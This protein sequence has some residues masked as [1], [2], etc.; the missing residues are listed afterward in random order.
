MLFWNKGLAMT[1]AGADRAIGSCDRDL[2]QSSGRGMRSKST[3]DHAMVDGSRRRWMLL[4]AVLCGVGL[5]WC[6]W[7]WWTDRRTRSAM[8]EIESEIVSGRYAIACRNLEKLLSW[9]ADPNGGIAYLLGSCELARGRPEAAGLAWARVVPGSAFSE[10]AIRGRMRLSYQSGEQAGAERVIE[11]AALD[12]RSDRTA[13]RAS[14]VPMF[15]E[16]GRTD[17]AERLIEDRWEHL[18]AIGEGALEPAIKLLLLHIGLTLTPTPVEKVRAALEQAA[19]LAPDDDRVW[20]GRANLAIRTGDYDEASRCLDECERLR[21]NDTPVW[22]ARLNWGIATNRINVVQ[23]A[24]H[25]LPAAEATPA[26]IGRLKVWFAANRH[27][28]GG[29]RRELESLL[30]SDPADRTALDRL[31][32]LAEIAGD[33]AQAVELR[34]RK[35]E[36]DALRSRYEKLYERKQPLRHAVEMAHLAERL[37]RR[38]EAQVFLTLAIHADPDREDLRRELARLGQSEPTVAGQARTLAEV[39][40]RKT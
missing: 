20:L 5:V 31:A 19:R 18:N 14:L 4:T 40:D 33:P 36:I 10:K 15:S 34:R 17:E 23:A 9:K 1:L 7:A 29:E 24:L 8:E 21:P 22:R 30:A 12:R 6:G 38:F 11:A 35:D 27:D 2:S 26:Q 32:H 25:H 28:A 39:L 13:L 3:G 37:G 16:Q